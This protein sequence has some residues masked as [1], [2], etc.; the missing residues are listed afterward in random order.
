MMAHTSD[1][2]TLRLPWHG[3]VSSEGIT[4]EFGGTILR[5]WFIDLSNENRFAGPMLAFGVGGGIKFNREVVENN[6]VVQESKWRVLV[7]VISLQFN[8]DAQELF[9]TAQD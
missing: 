7:P 6:L 4:S 3:L 8:L 2:Q 5:K 9:K 1:F